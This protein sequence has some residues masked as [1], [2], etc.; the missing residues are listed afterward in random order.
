M[1]GI[2]KLIVLTS[3]AENSILFNPMEEQKRYY[4]EY[5]SR[6]ISSNWRA[7]RHERLSFE[8]ALRNGVV[9]ANGI[10][11]QMSF[12]RIVGNPTA[13][14]PINPQEMTMGEQEARK[15]LVGYL[16]DQGH[17]RKKVAP[18]VNLTEEELDEWGWSNPD[19]LTT[20]QTQAAE[21]LSMQKLGQL[22]AEAESPSPRTLTPEERRRAMDRILEI[23]LE[24]TPKG[25]YSDSRKRKYVIS[26]ETV[27]GIRGFDALV[28]FRRE[29]ILF[30]K[31]LVD[32]GYTEIGNF[33]GGRDHS[34]ISYSEEKMEQELE[35]NPAAKKSF[36][37]EQERIRQILKEEGL[38][39]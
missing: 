11:G 37:A 26:R 5:A 21:I 23:V 4:P 36:L 33:L 9:L 18:A 39:E 22:A 25:E 32:V 10:F 2:D 15:M 35:L 14:R 13:R 28:E 6:T 3:E 19:W 24:N 16:R 1:W 8:D 27:L 30:V 34:T 12:D 20:A 29:F 17:A 38:I 31:G 7:V